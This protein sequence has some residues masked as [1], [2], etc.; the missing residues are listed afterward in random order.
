M[1]TDSTHWLKNPVRMKILVKIPVKTKKPVNFPVRMKKP[2]RNLY[3]L[4]HVHGHGV[5]SDTPSFRC[6]S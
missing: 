2:V 6:S 3:G 4:T 5:L 1:V